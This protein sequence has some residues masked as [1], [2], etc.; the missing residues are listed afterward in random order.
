MY[1]MFQRFN[2]LISALEGYQPNRSLDHVTQA[3]SRDGPNSPLHTSDGIL[4]IDKGPT[5]R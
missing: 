2:C 4:S 3:V 5:R 1:A